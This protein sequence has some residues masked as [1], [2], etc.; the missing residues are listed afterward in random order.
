MKPLTR[1]QR[2]WHLGWSWW[3]RRVRV[4]VVPSNF[5]RPLVHYENQGEDFH[6][7]SIGWGNGNSD[8]AF[9]VEI[10]LGRKRGK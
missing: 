7:V 2:W 8:A 6:F 3:L 4:S 9:E 10:N 1:W 5:N